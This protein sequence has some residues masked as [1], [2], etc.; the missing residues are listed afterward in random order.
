MTDPKPTEHLVNDAMDEKKGRGWIKGDWH[1]VDILRWKVRA[2]SQ[3]VREL[4]EK[5]DKCVAQ[6]GLVQHALEAAAAKEG[7]RG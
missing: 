2:Q 5:L 6:L 3:R 1:Q 4:E 7:S